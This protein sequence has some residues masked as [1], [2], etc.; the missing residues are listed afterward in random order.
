MKKRY[1]VPF[2]INKTARENVLEWVGNDDRMMQFV[3]H[4]D[5]HEIKLRFT[6]G[7]DWCY[8]DALTPR[9]NPITAGG[10]HTMTIDLCGDRFLLFGSSDIAAGIA[11]LEQMYEVY[12]EKALDSEVQ[13]LLRL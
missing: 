6:P 4:C 11:R 8:I 13:S 3:T 5:M 9:G 12:R 2:D 7:T 10:R 1:E